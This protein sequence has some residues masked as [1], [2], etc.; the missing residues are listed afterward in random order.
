MVFIKKKMATKKAGVTVEI[1]IS[2]IMTVTALFLI[3]HLFTTN[4]ASIAKKN[5]MGNL[6]GVNPAADTQK[7]VY[8]SWGVDPTKTQ[9]NVQVVGE[10]G[11]SWYI[12]D[13]KKRMEKYYQID[14]SSRKLNFDEVEDLARAVTILVLADSTN[15]YPNFC[16]DYGIKVNL[17]G[18][19]ANTTTLTK[20]DG[21]ELQNEIEILSFNNDYEKSTLQKIKSIH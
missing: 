1:T 10:H 19:N 18:K 15:E 4:L 7:T 12:T 2:A 11:L 17:S 14:F 8:E 20:K 13:S 21:V 6:L 5:G 3:L 9:V 16:N